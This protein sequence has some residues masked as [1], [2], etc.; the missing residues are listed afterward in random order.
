VAV[1]ALFGNLIW[2]TYTVPNGYTGA[3]V[4]DSNLA[5]DLLRGTVFASTGD[6]YSVPTDPAYVACGW[7]RPGF[8]HIPR[9]SLGLDS[10]SWHVFT[11]KVKWATRLMHW[12]QQTIQGMANGTD[13]WNVD[14]DLSPSNSPRTATTS[15]N[16][17][18]DYD[19][20]SAP[21]E[22]TYL[23]GFG[24]ETIL[25]G[26]KR[27]AFTIAGFGH[28]RI[29]VA[30]SGRPWV[31]SGGMEWGGPP[32]ASASVWRFITCTV[33]RNNST[34]HAGSWSALDPAT[35]K[36]VWQL[37]DP[38]RRYRPWTRDCG[39][40]R[41]LCCFQGRFGNGADDVC[42]DASTGN[43][44]WSFAAGSSVIAGATDR[45]P[46]KTLMCQALHGHSGD[47]SCGSR[48]FGATKR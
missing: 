14:C 17:G 5:V 31:F 13:F 26:T 16:A 1:S 2:K 42:T 20:S 24:L 21:S 25:G 47:H 39:Q 29:T 32:M 34:I 45:M 10:R 30:E 3:G 6:N 4:W 12:N 35:G 40:W 46:C 43:T 41:G 36:I 15:P 11:G 28:R 7:R 8:V 19:F 9:R 44:I 33:S 38:E 27:A 23:S 22:I 37:A 18:P 48:L